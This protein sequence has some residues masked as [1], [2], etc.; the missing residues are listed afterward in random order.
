MTKPT[1][2][3]ALIILVFAAG[4]GRDEPS[5]SAFDTDIIV[6][7]AGPAGL[8]AALEVVAGGA[9]VRI[10]E[11]NSVGGGHGAMAGGFALVGTPLQEK[12]GI[13]DSPELAYADWMAYGE[14]NDPDWTR[15]Y[16]ER[17]R[18]D[19]YEW[20]T[21]LGVE[22]RLIIPTPDASVP[23]F[24]FT[25][26]TSINVVVPMMR[27]ALHNPR[28]EFDFNQKA[29]SLIIDGDRITG[30]QT[31]DQ[32]T[33]RTQ[34]LSARAIVLATGGFQ[35][36]LDRV[37][38]AWG[39]AA[40]FPERMLIG[41]SRFALGS[42]HDLVADAGGVFALL[43]RQVVFPNG[44]PDPRAP[45]RALIVR[46]SGAIWVNARGERFTNEEALEK[47]VVE[48]ILSQSP[49]SYWMIFDH[50]GRRK[51]SVRDALWLNRETI[52][53]E[54]I[55]NPELTA[56]ADTLAELAQQTG[57]PAEALMRTVTD[58]NHAIDIGEDSQF[59]R[60][61][62]G[63]KIR[64]VKIMQPPFYALKL[65]PVARKNM[66]GVRIDH[67]GHVLDSRGTSIAGLF[68]AG[69]L[70]GMV[71]INGS[72]AITGT[73][74]GPAVFTGRIAGQGALASL[75]LDAGE[76]VPGAPDDQ[77]AS[78]LP[79]AGTPQMLEPLLTGDRPGYWH[80]T[81]AHQLVLERGDECGTCHT[82][83]FP[84]APVTDRATELA[85]LEVCTNCH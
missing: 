3:L 41:G 25:Q 47:E 68:A 6:V 8:A 4:C 24:H 26:G 50:K 1:I 46:A 82:T 63:E 52:D 72:H 83:K 17:S 21:A 79:L 35:G 81:K 5:D 76:P 62:P 48:S 29:E 69:E 58:F 56:K 2:A 18:A 42:G 12:R 28:I 55:N 45:D 64:A 34:R 23:R 31:R 53:R 80:F 39:T 37:R 33:G 51:T 13:Q 70:T 67:S 9:T 10:V 43:D 22:F 7:G 57:L 19:V 71:G 15:R 84:M 73:F 27:A 44:V 85:R 20:L 40:P 66:G 36:D 61:K 65:Y 11:M 59:G 32:R 78:V 74:L 77:P 16:A 14:T 60:F 54:I 75:G 30:V 38:A 49:A